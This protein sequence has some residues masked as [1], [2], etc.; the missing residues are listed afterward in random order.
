MPPMATNFPS[1]EGYV[2]QRHIDYYA[3]RAKGG[4]GLI[5]VEGAYVDPKGKRSLE[6]TM[7]F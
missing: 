5:L 4:A 1:P 6:Q 2:T 3:E 7:S